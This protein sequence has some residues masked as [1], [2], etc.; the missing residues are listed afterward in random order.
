MESY[1]FDLIFSNGDL[2]LLP[3]LRKMLPALV[4]RLA[5]AGSLA[6]QNPNNLCEQ[7]R[8]L[9]R[10]VAADGPWAEKLLSRAKTRPF[11]E[12]M[13]ILYELL[14]PVCASVD[15][16]ETTY[17]Y[18]LKG[19]GAIIDFVGATSLAPF[20][21]PL[22]ESSRKR[23]LDRYEIE[24]ARAYPSLTDGRVPLRFPKIFLLAR[25]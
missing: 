7:N 4:M 18:D 23:F 2:D 21:H 12:T 6:V 11:N 10:M 20:L 19:V 22:D 17:L 15:I 5:R 8:A 1:E 9:L 24:L 13:E 3:A 25:R 14:N 16:W